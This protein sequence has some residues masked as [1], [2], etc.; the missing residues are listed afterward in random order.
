MSEPT[1]EEKEQTILM[2]SEELVGAL[3]AVSKQINADFYGET[4]QEEKEGVT[5][6]NLLSR[7]LSNLR[8]ARGEVVGIVEQ[9]QIIK[10]RLG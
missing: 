2:A 4:P 6:V 7:I 5:Q 3:V 1:R 9:L 8:D 10:S